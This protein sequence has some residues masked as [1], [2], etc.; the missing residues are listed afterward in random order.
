MG[1]KVLTLCRTFYDGFD[2]AAKLG[3]RDELA[4]KILDLVRAPDPDSEDVDRK[5]GLIIDAE[6][7]TTFA[8][9]DMSGALERLEDTLFPLVEFM[10]KSSDRAALQRL[11]LFRTRPVRAPG[12]PQDGDGGF[13]SSIAD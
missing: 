7:Q 6:F 11:S 13:C 10:G 9:H 1:R 4:R 2:V 8:E 3:S 5:I 12:P